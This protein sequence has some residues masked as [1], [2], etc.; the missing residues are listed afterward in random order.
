LIYI[1]VLFNSI[2]NKYNQYAPISNQDAMVEPSTMNILSR[3]YKRS[4]VEYQSEL[5]TY[6]CA[7]LVNPHTDILEWWRINEANYPNL[8]RFARDCLPIPATSVP[9]EQ[10][11][12]ISG[13]MIT[14][15]RSRLSDKTVRMAMCL[16]SW[17][18]ELGEPYVYSLIFY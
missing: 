1:Y 4:R 8:S 12:S 16:Q 2:K 3:I 6:L 13:N 14:E 11:F 15:K 7:P 17:W 18:K 9:S 10:V 5:E